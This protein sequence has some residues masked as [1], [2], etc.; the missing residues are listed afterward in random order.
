MSGTVAVYSAA[1]NTAYDPGTGNPDDGQK[2]GDGEDENPDDGQKPGTGG[3]DQ[4]PGTA[5]SQTGGQNTSGKKAA[6]TGD[7]SN[8]TLYLLLAL[9]AAGSATAVIVIRRRKAQ[10]KANI[11]SQDRTD[12]VKA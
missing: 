2:P 11:L 9:A 1:A 12:K 6:R 4:K 8:Y 3:E 7:G 10:Q 5:D